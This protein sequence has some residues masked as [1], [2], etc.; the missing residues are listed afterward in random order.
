MVKNLRSQPLRTEGVCPPWAGSLVACGDV[1][2]VCGC[3]EAC[4]YMKDVGGVTFC[5][6]FLS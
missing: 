5:A 6:T 1:V 4:P 2:G 3:V